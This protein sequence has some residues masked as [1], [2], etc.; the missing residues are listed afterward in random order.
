[1]VEIGVSGRRDP[2]RVVRLNVSVA[3]AEAAGSVR[4]VIAKRFPVGRR[5]AVTLVVG[6]LPASDAVVAMDAVAPATGRHDRVKRVGDVKRL[7]PVGG[8]AAAVL[9]AGRRVYVSGQA[10]KGDTAAEAARKTLAS[11]RATLKG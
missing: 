9:P 11:L 10:E 8:S 7:S 2:E 3:T 5:P 6:K 1:L 4:E